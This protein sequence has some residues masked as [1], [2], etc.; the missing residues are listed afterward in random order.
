[1][2][3][4]S[5][6][7]AYA[8][9]VLRIG[10]AVLYLWFGF[11]EVTNVQMWTSYVPSW[12]TSMS[13]LSVDTVVLFNGLFEIAMGTLLALGFLVRWVALILALHMLLIVF[14][15]GLTAIG[16]RD[17]AIATSTLALSLFGSDGLTLDCRMA[18]TGPAQV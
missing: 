13:G 18:V 5:K 4:P 9:V 12:A 7:R 10:L 14:D 15:I 2:N 1:M 6:A 17:L 16:M 8:P 3:S 11:S